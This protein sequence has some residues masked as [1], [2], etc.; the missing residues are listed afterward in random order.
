LNDDANFNKI[1][2]YKSAFAVFNP[3][4]CKGHSGSDIGPLTSKLIV[5]AGLKPIRNV[6]LIII[7]RQ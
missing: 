2:S 7:M 5:K 4:F 1:S 3:Q 6:I